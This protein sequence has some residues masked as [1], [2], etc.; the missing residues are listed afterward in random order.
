MT[1]R[2]RLLSWSF[3]LDRI[4][5]V[6]AI[7]REELAL[8]MLSEQDW[9]TVGRELYSRAAKYSNGSEHNESGLFAFEQA[10]LDEHFPAPPASLLVGACGGGRELF[11]LVERGYRIAAAYDPVTVFIDALRDEPRLFEYR[12]R[13]CVGSHQKLEAML[14]IAELRQRGTPID[15]ALIGWGSYTHILGAERR[16]EFLRALRA[17]CPRG[18]VLVSFFVKVEDEAER[19][20][21]FRSRLRRLLG[22]TDATVETGDG[23]H[24]GAGAVHYFTE[25]SFATE[26]TTAGYR[27]QLWQEHGAAAGHAVLIPESAIPQSLSGSA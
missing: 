23:L 12:D 5:R 14:P 2:A 10:A 26:A 11:A 13:I 17:L 4:A 6:L 21:R 9:L 15:A 18:P 25:T 22:T 20:G 7:T 3:E 16:V 19:P 8:H 1:L 27:V 24:R